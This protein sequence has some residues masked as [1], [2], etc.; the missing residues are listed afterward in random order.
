MV[1][2]VIRAMVAIASTGYHLL[3]GGCHNNRR[4]VVSTTDSAK[5]AIACPVRD[6]DTTAASDERMGR[7]MK[8]TAGRAI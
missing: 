7:E 2:V 6:A 5:P 1:Y 4:G 3:P 8:H